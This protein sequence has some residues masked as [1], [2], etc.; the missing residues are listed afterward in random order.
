MSNFDKVIEFNKAFGL[1]HSDVPQKKIF[2]ENKNL[3]KLRVDL[4]EEEFNVQNFSKKLYELTN[5][6]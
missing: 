5:I 6:E 4:I 2:T 1:P 3:T